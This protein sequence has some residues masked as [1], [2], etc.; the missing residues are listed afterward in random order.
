MPTNGNGLYRN[1]NGHIY[2]F[3]DEHSDLKRANGRAN[4]LRSHGHPT[5]VTRRG[6]KWDVCTCFEYKLSS[7]IATRNWEKAQSERSL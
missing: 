2:Y 4:I 3:M 5:R 6:Y 7:T 1:W